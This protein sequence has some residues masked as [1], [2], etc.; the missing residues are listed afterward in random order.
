MTKALDLGCGPKPKCIFDCQEIWG[1]DVN[2][3]NN[4]HIRVADLAIEPIPFK[5]E[6]FDIV[7]AYD[8]IEHIPRVIYLPQRRNSFIELMNEVYRVLKPQGIFYSYTPAFPAPQAFRDPEHVNIITEETFTLYFD[9]H[10][11]WAKTYGFKG[12]FKI[13]SQ[14]WHL[15][16]IHLI[17]IMRRE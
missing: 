17:T 5:D 15:N 4:P 6:E 3:Y 12:K 1:V 9:N 16:K 13:E 8:F 7:T 2:N 10:H 14:S 11:T